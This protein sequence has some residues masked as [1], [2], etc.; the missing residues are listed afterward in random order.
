MR[1]RSRCWLAST[2]GALQCVAG[3][4]VVAA[5]AHGIVTPRCGFAAAQKP[6]PKNT[7]GIMAFA[8]KKKTCLRC[9]VPLPAGFPTLCKHC[10]PHEAEV[11]A[12]TMAKVTEAEHKHSRLWTECQRCQGSMQRDVICSKYVAR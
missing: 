1:T 7:A 6:T 3:L 5:Y 9:R 8:K 11:Y 2:R 4:V 10:L 12:K